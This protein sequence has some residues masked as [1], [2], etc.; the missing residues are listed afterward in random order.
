[1]KTFRRHIRRQTLIFT[2]AMMVIMAGFI[3]FLINVKENFYGLLFNI[4]MI[5]MLIILQL[6]HYRITD[7]HKLEVIRIGKKPVVSIDILQ[8]TS[9]ERLKNNQLR[10]NHAKGFIILD[11]KERDAFIE[12]LK[13]HN[14]AIVA[15]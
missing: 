5:I 1:M 4:P 11:I 2:L 9:T 15:K 12:E 6:E 8:I 14:P 7:A 13:K 3:Y 10:I